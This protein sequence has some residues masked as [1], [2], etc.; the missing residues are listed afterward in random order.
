MKAIEL[1]FPNWKEYRNR[2]DWLKL[3]SEKNKLI[4][5]LQNGYHRDRFGIVGHECMT[6]YAE[7][8]LICS[9]GTLDGFG[10]KACAKNDR[11]R[12]WAWISWKSH[13][14][15]RHHTH[16]PCC[17]R[18]SSP[19]WNVCISIYVSN[20]NKKDTPSSTHRKILCDFKT[21][22]LF[23]HPQL[24]MTKFNVE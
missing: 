17:M 14:F 4:E 6:D 20:F 9:I 2:Y 11:F 15:I 23:F 1:I 22:F 3:N 19:L 18:L 10:A 21:H 7:R 13:I 8:C 16:T 5:N 24:L 12:L